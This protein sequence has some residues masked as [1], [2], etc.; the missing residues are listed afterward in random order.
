MDKDDRQN[1]PTGYAVDQVEFAADDLGHD[2]V[3]AAASGTKLA[4]KQGRNLFQR[5]REKRASEGGREH[6]TPAEQAPAS[7]PVDLGRQIPWQG[8]DSPP[9]NRF[10]QHGNTFPQNTTAKCPDADPVSTVERGRDYARKQTA[11][12]MERTRQIQNR[13][14]QSGGPR[15]I[16]AGSAATA[17]R[18]TES[19][20]NMTK[21]PAQ[22]MR[23]AR[24]RNPRTTQRPPSRTP[25]GRSKTRGIPSRPLRTQSKPLSKPQIRQ[26]WQGR[27]Q[28]KPPPGPRKQQPT[29]LALRQRP[30]LSPQKALPPQRR[31]RLRL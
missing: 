28:R 2:A 10:P 1:T 23:R 26:R 3:N 15:Q 30:P 22:P 4:I 31:R 9:V 29:P 17:H 20:I 12:R 16:D 7:E 14:G 27:K 19:A 11:K 18:Q 25:S 13:M 6:T 21:Q 8:G 24:E 5:Q